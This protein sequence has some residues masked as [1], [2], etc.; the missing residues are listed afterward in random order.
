MQLNTTPGPFPGAWG[1]PSSSMQE[2]WEV[3]GAGTLSLEGRARHHPCPSACWLRAAGEGPGQ[4]LPAGDR[5][6]GLPAEEPVLAPGGSGLRS[7]Q[8]PIASGTQQFQQLLPRQWARRIYSWTEPESSLTASD[9]EKRENS[10]QH[11][12]AR[13]WPR[14]LPS[15]ASGNFSCS[16][17]PF[18]LNHFI[19]FSKKTSANSLA[20]ISSASVFSNLHFRGGSLKPHFLLFSD[21]PQP[22]SRQLLCLL[23]TVAS[24]LPAENG[25]LRGKAKALAAS[26]Y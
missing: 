6:P 1:S 4:Y 10:L 2:A 7:C 8:P 23:D 17:L 19:I 5:L 3:P 25:P 18:A 24:D 11:R 12:Q 20:A 22:S 14:Q 9:L 13:G 15:F 21:S 26:F 16:V